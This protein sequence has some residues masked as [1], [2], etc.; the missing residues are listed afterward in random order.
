MGW[1]TEPVTP[2]RGRE[3]VFRKK[4]AIL[5]VLR[6][7]WIDR[8]S[9]Q[10]KETRIVLATLLVDLNS[11]DRIVFRG[12]GRVTPHPTVT[13]NWGSFRPPESDVDGRLK[14]GPRWG[15]T[16]GR[17]VSSIG[18]SAPVRDHRRCRSSK[19][20]PEGALA[21]STW[22]Q[23]VFGVPFLTLGSGARRRRRKRPD[24]LPLRALPRSRHPAVDQHDHTRPHSHERWNRSGFF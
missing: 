1:P 20:S 19:Q 11:V 5:R 14:I 13:A 2:T 12:L 15:G 18:H 16:A 3:F 6:E 4:P 10:P 9:P 22:I 8:V 24:T 23:W 7:A 17:R 21:P